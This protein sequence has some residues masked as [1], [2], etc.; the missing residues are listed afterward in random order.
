VLVIYDT[1]WESTAAMAQAILDGAS[2]PGVEASLISIRRSSLTYIA[3][4]VLAAAAVAFG[5]STLN[6]GMMPMAAA[7]LAYLE[8]L[9]PMNKAAFAFGSYGW[10]VGG[11]EAVDHALRRLDWNILR[12]PLRAKYRP[13]PEILEQCRQAGVLLAQCAANQKNGA[14]DPKVE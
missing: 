3:A 6:R 4:E 11:A 13:T 8:G 10:G 2:Q 1:M 9:R 5:S 14:G 12:E 7:V